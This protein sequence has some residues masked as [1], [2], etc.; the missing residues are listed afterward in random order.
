MNQHQYYDKYKRDKEAKRF[1]NSDAWKK[2][3]PIILTRDRYLCQECLRKGILTPANTV[4]HIKHYKEHPELALD[5]N[6]LEVICDSCHNKEHPEKGKKK[7]KPISQKIKVI[8][9]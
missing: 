7:K 2:C 9:G 1:Y 8:K 5:P 3:R 6:N 4:H